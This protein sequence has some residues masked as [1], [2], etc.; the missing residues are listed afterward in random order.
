[1]L[2]S[3]SYDIMCYFAQYQKTSKDIFFSWATPL[4]PSIDWDRWQ[5]YAIYGSHPLETNLHSRSSLGV[6]HTD[7]SSNSLDQ[8]RSIHYSDVIM[9]TIASRITILTIVYS[10][11]YSGADHRKHQSSASLA[12]VRGIRQMA[13]NAENVSICWRHHVDIHMI[14]TN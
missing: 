14:A 10:T 11:V 4:A 12:F 1:M 5:W 13:S 8:C 3:V 6:L 9:D 7:E 2:S